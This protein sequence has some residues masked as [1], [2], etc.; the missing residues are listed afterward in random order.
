MIGRKTSQND[1]FGVAGLAPSIIEPDSFYALLHH[2]GP[3]VLSDMDF[4]SMYDETLGR[5]SIPPSLLASVLLLQRHDKVSD[6]EAARRVRCDLSWKHALHLP[7]DHLGFAHANLCHFRAR[8]VVHGLEGMPFD[9]LNRLAVDLGIL[10]PKAPRAMDSSH[11]FGAAAVQDTYTL[12]RTSFRKLLAALVDR[13]REAAGALIESLDLSKYE[14]ADKPEIDWEDA[15]ARGEWL[16]AIVRDSRCLLGEIDGTELVDNTVRQAASLLTEIL[17]QDITEG[18]EIKEGVAKDRII[19]TVDTEMRHGRKSSSKRFDGYKVHIGEDLQTE[20]I[21]DVE[22]SAGNAHD[23]EPVEAM[24]EE[25]AQKLGAFPEEILGDSHYGSADLRVDLAEHKIEVVA[26]LPG[27]ALQ[28][29]DRFAK[30][31]FNIDLDAE[32]VT[33]PGGHTTQKFYLVRDGKDRR[34]RSYRF[35]A[36]TC[37][38]CT[39]K[40]ACTSSPRGRSITLH[41][42]EK[43][44]C[45]AHA[46]NQTEEFKTK[47]R[48]RALVER[49]APRNCS[50]DTACALDT[51]SDSRR[52]VC[53]LCGRRWL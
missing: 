50:S 28:R 18:G 26:K 17:S 48:R 3:L 8:L 37:N 19:S 29:E 22:V 20:L 49:E 30:T 39:L 43:T 11:I 23:S 40:A 35:P 7:I 2:A 25:S 27:V 46:Y 21:T 14:K 41:Y 10:D 1:L 13:D 34:V 42:H 12:L 5:P 53:R 51:T 9:K 31:D 15:G 24:L 33:C 38:V 47:Y 52:F 36:R 45:A 44:L 4:A 16:R 6:R 32:E